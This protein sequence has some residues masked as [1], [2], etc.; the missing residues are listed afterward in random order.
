MRTVHEY[1]SK[2]EN[3]HLTYENRILNPSQERSA[4]QYSEAI[5][6][7][8]AKYASKI[9]SRTL[10]IDELRKMERKKL[11]FILERVKKGEIIML[12]NLEFSS[13]SFENDF[14]KKSGN[15]NLES[16]IQENRQ[17]VSSFSEG[18][19]FYR[20]YWRFFSFW[21]V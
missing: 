9:G 18:I 12:S 21:L 7:D 10:L 13:E 2:L 3:L 15:P 4:N 20:K 19:K 14:I 17:I 16:G 5:D 1:E 11:E 6:A 8:L